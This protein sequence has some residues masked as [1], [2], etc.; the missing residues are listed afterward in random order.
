MPTYKQGVSLTFQ[1]AFLASGAKGTGFTVNAAIYR[2]TSA[3]PIDS[4]VATEIGTTGRYY[5]TLAANLNNADGDYVAQFT[6]ADA[7]AD[8]KDLWTIITVRTS[9]DPVAAEVWSYASRTLTQ[10]SGSFDVVSTINGGTLTLYEQET[11]EFTYSNTNLNLAPY[12]TIVFGIKATPTDA[13][14][15]ALCILRSDTGLSILGAASATAGDGSLTI[16][17]ATQFTVLIAMSAISS[18]I[19]NTNNGEY[20]WYLKAFDT[21][22]TPDKG[23][24]LIAGTVNLKRAGIRTTS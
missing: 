11:W 6:T 2:G 9:G 5:Y 14:A 4:G 18:A 15:A 20:Y 3:T 12:E 1:A 22:P 24:T 17:S 23:K 8:V 21:T 10:G 13:D 16:D 19:G 7:S